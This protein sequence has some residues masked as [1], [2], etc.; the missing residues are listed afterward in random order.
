M[1]KTWYPVIDYELCLEC[2][3][4]VEMCPHGVYDKARNPVPLVIF[5]EGCIQGC[6]GC[7]DRCPAGAIKHVGSTAE[8]KNPGDNSC[9]CNC[10]EG[11]KKGGCC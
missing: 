11:E 2:G 3:N 1:S 5:P 7:G 6:H 10:S 4:C 8:N 9:S